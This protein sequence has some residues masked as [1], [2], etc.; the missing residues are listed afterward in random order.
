[1]GDALTLDEEVAFFAGVE[2][3]DRFQE[4]AAARASLVG[5]DNAVNG[6]FFLP[7]TGETDMYGHSRVGIPKG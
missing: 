4:A 2:R 1:M 7:S 5:D 6:G 3:A